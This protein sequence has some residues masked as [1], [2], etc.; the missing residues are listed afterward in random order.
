MHKKS[1]SLLSI[2]SIGYIVFYTTYEKMSVDIK[3]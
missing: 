2:I 3:L 1:N